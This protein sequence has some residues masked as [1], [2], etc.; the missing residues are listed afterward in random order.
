MAF[1][2]KSTLFDYLAGRANPMKRQL[3]ETWLRDDANRSTF[4]AWLLEWERLHPQI[5]PDTDAAFDRLLRRI[6]ADEPVSPF[7]AGESAGTERRVTWFPR[8]LVAA[9]VLLLL[10]AGLFLSRDRILYRTYRTAYGQTR[11]IQLPDGTLVTLNA[12]ST[13]RVS[14]WFFGRFGDG[15]RAVWLAGEAEFSVTHQPNHQRFV[16]RTDNDFRVEVLGTVFSMYARPQRAQVVLSRGKVRVDAGRQQ[17]LM[18]PGDRVTLRHGHLHRYQTPRPDRYAA[19]KNHQFVFDGTSV[20]DVCQLLTDTFGRRVTPADSTLARRAISGQFR[21]YTA[22]ELLQVLTEV[23]NLRV[24][25][26]P[27]HLILIAN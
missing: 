9:T 2:L 4:H 13:L 20:A 27:D 21:A 7:R 17:L 25:K 5:D 12:N 15:G 8:W 10:S 26:R 24:E 18:K 23:L 6:D 14:R 19:W 22:D 1:L 11:P 16:V 3:V